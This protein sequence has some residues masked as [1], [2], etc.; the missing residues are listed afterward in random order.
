MGILYTPQVTNFQLQGTYVFEEKNYLDVFN[1]TFLNLSYGTRE[2]SYIISSTQ[3][4]GT[5]IKVHD[6]IYVLYGGNLD[7]SY[8][9][10]DRDNK[11]YLIKNKK[12]EKLFK[13]DNTITEIHP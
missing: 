1:D 13:F 7:G 9:V 5:F 4:Q 3:T 11:L 8:V 2:Y 12:V 6:N 10:I